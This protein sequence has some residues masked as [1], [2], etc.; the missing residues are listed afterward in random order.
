MDRARR[1]SLP[2][3]ESLP[4]AVAA[5]FAFDG[6]VFGSWAAR[7][8]DV[9]AQVGTS[10]AGLRLALLCVSIGALASM[11]VAGALC[12]RHGAG[13]VT[14]ASAVLVCVAVVLPGLAGSLPELAAALLA[15]GA[16]TGVVNVA[17]NSAG[18]RLETA[19]DRP[20]MPG[21]HAAFSFGGLAGAALGAVA[22]GLGGVAPHL[23]AVAGMGL[24][25][26]GV[27]APVLLAGDRSTTGAAD[28]D[29]SATLPPEHAVGTDRS[30]APGIEHRSPMPAPRRLL[31][32]LGVIAGC[33]AYGEGAITD[34]GALHLRETLAASPAVA[35]AGY[36]AFS[37]AMACGRLTGGRL[38]RSFGA[39]HVLVVGSTL[40]AVGMLAAALAPVAAVAL[41]GF[42]LVGL[43]LA[44]V[45]P[46]AIA[47][48]GAL[49][50]SK[51]VAL[52]STV[53]YTGLL[54]GPP[55][56][57]L[58]VAGVGLPV[59]LATVSL[60]AAVAAG[61]SLY[62]TPQRV[63]LY[64]RVADALDA[65]RDQAVAGL[66]PTVLRYRPAVRRWA[67][68]L[69]LLGPAAPGPARTSTPLT[70][71]YLR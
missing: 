49:G 11:Q 36:A 41:A 50:G 25:L 8:P 42:A 53:G 1:G 20:I 17:A 13:L 58:L 2:S 31:V 15:F 9:T 23:L 40:A 21:L 35:A 30:P 51:G 67:D 5:L 57:G 52:A 47:R 46:L 60:L 64:A 6:A 48:A 4:A 34:W 33:T 24:V 45:F 38:V 22:S 61:L 37:L 68:D 63:L 12:A 59:A 39:T 43:G 70:A 62:A 18:V 27:I 29:R 10:H 69:A 32:V 65:G 14:V 55:V 3:R 7:I 71:V 44:N 19:G 54:C 56:I 16:A 66:A 26:T 28:P